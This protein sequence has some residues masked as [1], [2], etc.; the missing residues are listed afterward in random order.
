MVA[1]P[2]LD[3]RVAPRGHRRHPEA[4]DW[5]ALVG[6]ENPG[7]MPF[8]RSLVNDLADVLGAPTMG[9]L[10]G[11]DARETSRHSLPEQP[12]LRNL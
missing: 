7:R 8:L 11:P 4:I 12:V 3:V 5:G 9:L 2:A 10:P 6:Q 1:T